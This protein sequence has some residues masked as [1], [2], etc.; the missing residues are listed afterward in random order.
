MTDTFAPNEQSS[1]IIFK[2]VESDDNYDPI[3]Y[4][5]LPLAFRDSLDTLASNLLDPDSGHMILVGSNVSG[6]TFLLHQLVGNIDRYLN[7]LDIPTFQFIRM[8]MEDLEKIQLIPGGYQTFIS[9]ICENFSCP[10]NLI[11]F[12]TEDPNVAS[13]LFW[14]SNKARIILEVSQYTFVQMMKMENTGATKTW[15]SWVYTDV[16][17]ITLQKNDLIDLLEVSIVKKLKETFKVDL[18]RKIIT[19]F[20]NYTLKNIPELVSKEKDTYNEIIAP[21]GIW[22]MAIRR[23]GGIMGLSESPVLRRGDKIVMSR[24]IESTFKDLRDLFDEFVDEEDDENS[25]VLKGP[26]GNLIRIPIPSLHIM[27]DEEDNEDGEEKTVTPLVFS[28]MNTLSDRLSKEVIGQDEAIKNIVEGLI[29]PA[30][31]LN[32]KT[33]PIRSFLFLGK[34]GVGKTKMALTLAEQLATTPMKL[35]RID[36][37]EYSQQHEAAKLLGAPPGYA[38]YERGG[39][40]TSAVAENPHAVVLLDEVEKAHPKIWDSFLQILD[41]GRMTDARGKVVD[42][43]Q[44]IIIMTSNLGANDLSK[45]QTGFSSLS[46]SEAY[47]Q[48][49]KDAKNIV[50]RAVEGNLRTE[51]IN[52]IDE[53]VLF[54]EISHDTAAKIVRKELNILSSRMKDSHFELTE[55]SDDIVKEIMSKSNIEKFGAR[56]IQRV[57]LRSVSNPIARVIMEAKRS[58]SSGK[59]TLVLDKDNIISVEKTLEDSAEMKM[60]G[61]SSV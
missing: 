3:M 19:L 58:K 56:E 31:G 44:T 61:D 14:L 30:A 23:L 46:E 10:E 6:K 52:R 20:V 1:N 8:T 9:Q 22:A 49:Q 40:L 29:V 36:M 33:K 39:I 34:T 4:E 55:V 38:G 7:R 57:I 45:K 51:L 24:V 54:R 53:I 48:R 16:N 25:I 43:S 35:I 2:I 28:D 41:A 11:C 13:R 21:F 27:D 12:V 5:K 37:S 17:A 26:E 60:N 50:M 42:F 59:L 18:S 15:S 32:D 47:E